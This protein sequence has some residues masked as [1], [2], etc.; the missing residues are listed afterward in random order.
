M[1][2][3]RDQLLADMQAARAR[4][5]DA[6]QGLSEEDVSRPELEGWS[7]KDHINHLTACDE[8]RFHEIRRV[9][10]G[11]RSAFTGFGTEQ[12]DSLNDL[13][14]SQRRRLPWAQ[15]FSDLNAARALVL[16]AI[17]AAPEDALDPGR[18]VMYPVNGSIPHDI[19]HAAAISAWRDKEE[20]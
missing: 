18:Y 13:L 3:I 1:T 7:V 5:L 12:G 14:V 9:S 19:S 2:H 6:V 17:G 8:F 11:G 20:I 10:R 15:A 4:V 16:E